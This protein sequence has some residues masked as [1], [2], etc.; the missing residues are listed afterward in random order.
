MFYQISA[1][2][3]AERN[4]DFIQQFIKLDDN[5]VIQYCF[6]NINASK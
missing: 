2:F 1:Q 5:I 6:S 3:A 4:I